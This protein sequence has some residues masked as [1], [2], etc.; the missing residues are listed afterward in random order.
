MRTLTIAAAVMLAVAAPVSAQP[1][2]DELMAPIQKF[3]SSFNKGDTAG[4]ASTH[5]AGADLTIVDE[6]APY[7]WRGPK[8]FHSWGADLEADAKKNGITE[9]M[10]TLS[11][12]TRTETSGDSAYV[13]V[14]AVYTFKL[15][16]TPM[17]EAAQMTFV[18][19]KGASGWLIHGWTWTG[20]RAQPAGGGVKK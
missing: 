8:A 10:V 17:R 16:G 2:N 15:K 9:S 6:V 1:T 4:A 11:A 5:A 18:L 13:V 3:I 19:K 20:P 7:L 12:A 14:P